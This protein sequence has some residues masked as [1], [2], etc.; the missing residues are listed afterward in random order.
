METKNNIIVRSIFCFTILIGFNF[1]VGCGGSGGGGSSSGSTPPAS[2]LGVSQGQIEGF[3]RVFV[4][5]V[6][7]GNR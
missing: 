6:E 5:G 1:M 3:G 4:N 7:W 2:T